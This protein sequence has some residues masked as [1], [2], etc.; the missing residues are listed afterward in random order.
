MSNEQPRVTLATAR[1]VAAAILFSMC[2]MTGLG[3]LIA[4]GT[5]PIGEAAIDPATGKVI[6]I[7]FLA[8]GVGAVGL[9]HIFHSVMDKRA[10]ASSDTA[11]GRYVA[12]IV[13]MALGEMPATLALVNGI[14]THNVT[15]TAMLGIAAI[16]TGLLHFPRA[17]MFE[18]R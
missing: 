11:R 7:V 2:M 17:G 5:L 4:T 9:S 12:T 16:I 13:S 8:A 15:T 14:V 1:I 10:D 18:Q 6:G 3:L